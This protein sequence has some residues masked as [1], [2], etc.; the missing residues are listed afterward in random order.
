MTRLLGAA[1]IAEV[2]RRSSEVRQPWSLDETVRYGVTQTSYRVYQE[3]LDQAQALPALKER[4]DGLL[5]LRYG[6]AGQDRPEAAAVHAVLQQ[7]ELPWAGRV[8][9]R[10]R[11]KQVAMRVSIQFAEALR[12]A[13]PAGL[14]C[15][16]RGPAHD[17]VGAVHRGPTH[18]GPDA[19]AA[20]GPRQDTLLKASGAPPLFLAR[21]PSIFLTG[22]ES[23]PLLT[24]NRG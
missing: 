2:R 5:R 6:A 15:T 22:A 21:H 23:H 24:A 16:H 14:N 4:V 1:E 9:L 3:L 20:A 10:K 12:L 11:P 17:I 19:P 7:A 13:P 18:T 8:T